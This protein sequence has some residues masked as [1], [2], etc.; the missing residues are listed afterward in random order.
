MMSRWLVG[1]DLDEV[2]SADR[3]A[4]NAI[5]IHEGYDAERIL[6]DIGL[7]E[8]ASDAPGVPIPMAGRW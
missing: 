8:L 5:H 7:V 3:I 4:V 2:S 6:H 1:V